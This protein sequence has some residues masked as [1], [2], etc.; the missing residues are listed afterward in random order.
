MVDSGSIL[1]YYFRVLLNYLSARG[2]IYIFFLK[3]S[4]C[5]VEGPCCEEEIGC[6][7]TLLTLVILLSRHRGLRGGLY[8]RFHVKFKIRRISKLL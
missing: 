4:E 6:V 7:E 8:I 5:G 3:L 2:Y 1:L